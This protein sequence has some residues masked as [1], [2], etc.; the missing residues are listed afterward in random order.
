MRPT[1]KVTA[2]R[3][4][5]PRKPTASLQKK[6]ANT[7]KTKQRVERELKWTLEQHGLTRS[8][9]AKWL[10]CPEQFASAYID[11]FTS[12]QL[13]TP[14]AYGSLW[15]L[16]EETAAMFGEQR[17]DVH[18][19]MFA[20]RK[21]LATYIDKVVKNHPGTR[22]EH[23]H[24]AE[25]VCAVFPHYLTTYRTE[26][27]SRKWLAREKTFCCPLEVD[28]RT[29]YLRGRR[30][31]DYQARTGALGLHETK[32]KSRIDIPLIMAQLGC[33]L[34]TLLYLWSMRKDYGITP[35]SLCYN[36]TRRPEERLGKGETLPAFYQRVSK[37]VAADKDH[38]FK[39]FSVTISGRDLDHFENILLRPLC[40]SFVLWWEQVK[41]RPF[42]PDRMDCDR[43]YINSQA[44]T[45]IYS[46][47]DLYEMIASRN[48]AGYHVKSYPFPELLSAEDLPELPLPPDHPAVE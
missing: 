13:S 23:T 14:L 40:R 2:V 19:I 4:N 46:K 32:T 43:H 39:R 3:R 28:G 41:Q 35:T 42:F 20:V 36:V 30:D 27:L 44:L 16:A 10:E 21:A 15:H 11:G 47:S 34:Q 17:A 45:G 38:Y 24:L 26:D 25:L 5:K 29:I 1:K 12:S 33:D 31:G 6:T 37:K 8:A 48:E 22:S 7:A 18:K 9:L